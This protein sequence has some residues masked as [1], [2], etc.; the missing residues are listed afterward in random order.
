M[1]VIKNIIIPVLFLLF[2]FILLL[3]DYL[4]YNAWLKCN[5]TPYCL[6]LEEIYNVFNRIATTYLLVLI[7]V[8]SVLIYLYNKYIHKRTVLKILLLITGIIILL[9]CYII[10]SA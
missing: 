8:F 3:L 6:N 2:L 4:S 10:F 1:K 9:N 7:L 5:S